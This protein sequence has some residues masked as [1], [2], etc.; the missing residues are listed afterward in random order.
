MKQDEVRG[1]LE[2]DFEEKNRAA[3]NRTISGKNLLGRWWRGTKRYAKSNL[4]VLRTQL[5]INFFIMVGCFLGALQMRLSGQLGVVGFILFGFGC[6]Q[7]ITVIM[8]FKQLKSVRIQEEQLE[9]YA[10]KEEEYILNKLKEE[11]NNV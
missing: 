4:G 2:K 6:L 7:L 1:L 3:V 11:S 10:K 9:T 8:S 5:I